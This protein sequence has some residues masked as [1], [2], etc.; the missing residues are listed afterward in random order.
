MSYLTRTYSTDNNVQLYADSLLDQTVFSFAID[1]SGHNNL[2]SVTD[3][4]G[5]TTK[6]GY[7]NSIIWLDFSLLKK[8]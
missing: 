3:C 7:I 6:F 2:Q 5:I 8:G 1:P 4:N